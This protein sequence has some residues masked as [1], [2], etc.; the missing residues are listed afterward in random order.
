MSWK[1]LKR[2]MV[3]QAGKMFPIVKPG[4]YLLLTMMMNLSLVL[5]RAR[6][7]LDLI[8]LLIQIL[9]TKWEQ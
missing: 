8:I 2:M 7:R 9:M 3:H 5:T 6:F 4:T 1:M